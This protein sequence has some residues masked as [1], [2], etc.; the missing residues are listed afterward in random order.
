MTPGGRTSS[1]RVNRVP[2]PPAAGS[3]VYVNVGCMPMI[4]PRNA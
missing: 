2:V 3:K 4:R 1:R